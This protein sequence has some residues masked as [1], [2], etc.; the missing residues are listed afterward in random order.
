MELESA[1]A[2][3][4][5]ELED[6]VIGV[7][8]K[9]AN[10]IA[11]FL[12]DPQHPRVSVSPENAN[13]IDISIAG[14]VVFELH[15]KYLCELHA[16]TQ[17]L[18]IINS[19]YKVVMAGKGA[20][21]WHYDYVRDMKKADSA[22]AHL[23][24]HAHRN[25]I[26]SAL[27][28]SKGSKAALDVRSLHFP[29]GGSRFRPTIEDVFEMLITEFKID[30]AYGA[31]SKIAKSRARYFERQIES[32]VFDSPDVAASALRELGYGVESPNIL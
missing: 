16:K 15:L 26:I 20:P 28:L 14:G 6:L 17:R 4:T 8:G 7:L 23:N 27:A 29:F 32:V 2:A 13:G 10:L 3:F 11:E 9:P 24:V 5:Q 30:K 1:S 25:E 12:P 18:T 31:L 21:L 19:S 22:I